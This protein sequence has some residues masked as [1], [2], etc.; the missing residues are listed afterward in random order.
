MLNPDGVARRAKRLSE[1]MA[2]KSMMT[3]DE[4]FFS[5]KYWK[6]KC[7]FQHVCFYGNFSWLMLLVVL[8]D[9]SRFGNNGLLQLAAMLTVALVFKFWVNRVYTL[10]FCFGKYLTLNRRVSSEMVMDFLCLG[11]CTESIRITILIL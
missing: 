5:E 4:F 3:L 8:I 9:I 1:S 6:I 2:P 7:R 11:T 10:L